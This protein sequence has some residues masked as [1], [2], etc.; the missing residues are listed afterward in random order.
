MLKLLANSCPLCASHQDI[1]RFLVP[2][3]ICCLLAP[4]KSVLWIRQLNVEAPQYSS[5]DDTH[6]S[7]SKLHAYTLVSPHTEG[8]E[9]GH[10]VFVLAF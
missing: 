3:D 1:Q 2:K 8:L 5:N 4:L 7:V 10:I 6:F 9:R